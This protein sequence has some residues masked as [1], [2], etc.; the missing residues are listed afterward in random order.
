M[1]KLEAQLVDN[2]RALEIALAAIKEI[3]TIL[4]EGNKQTEHEHAYARGRITS[5]CWFADRNARG[6]AGL[7]QTGPGAGNII[8]DYEAS[9][10]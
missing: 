6:M 3:H 2:Q 7:E 1:N 5:I 8:P 4:V 9:K 10:S